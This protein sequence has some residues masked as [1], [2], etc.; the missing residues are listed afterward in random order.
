MKLI[1][2]NSISENELLDTKIC[3]LEVS[4]KQT[5]LM[6]GINDLYF[7]LNSKQINFLPTVWLSND[8]FSPD[9]VCGFAIPFYLVHPTLIKLELKNTG[10]VEGQSYKSF[11]QLLRH[12]TGHAIDNAFHLRKSKKRQNLF[13]LSSTKY[14]TS[15]VPKAN[16]KDHVRHLEEFYAQ[17]HPDEDWAE[18]FAVWLDP[19]SNWEKKYKSWPALEKLNFVDQKMKLLKGKNQIVLKKT[20]IDS[21]SLDTRTLSEYYKDKR[22]QLKLNK[23]SIIEQVDSD[24]LKFIVT[25]PQKSKRLINK[26]SKNKFISEKMIKEIIKKCKN[27]NFPLEYSN[28]DLV[29]DDLNKL[30]QVYIKQGRHKVIM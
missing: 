28:T 22:K 18:T 26:T 19:K 16:S 25:N 15:Y 6:R 7:E 14:P 12:E 24:L 21:I 5:S 9:G 11:M 17:A 20:E 27:E 8:W 10:I 30:M 1:D 4:L 2:L 23:R 29:E 3:D 13:G